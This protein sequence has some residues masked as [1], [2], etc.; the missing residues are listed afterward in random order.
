MRRLLILKL[1]AYG[2]LLV[3]LWA[4]GRGFGRA[5]SAMSG[6]SAAEGSHFVLWLL[7]YVALGVTLGLLAAWDFSTFLGSA[8]ERFVL[9]TGARGMR[10]DPRLKQ[11]EALVSKQEPLEAI[12]LLREYL[13]DKPRD[14]HAAIRIAEIYQGPLNN[15][16]AAVLEYEALLQHG[17]LPR[18]AR[19]W[20]LLRLGN[21]FLFLGR[22]DAATQWFEEIL[23]KYPR[24][25]AAEKAQRRLDAANPEA[26][27]TE[28]ADGDGATEPAGPEPASPPQVKLPPGFR[29][30]EE[31]APRR[32]FWQK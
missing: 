23:R 28:A 29:R 18:A 20:I 4:V 27:E 16:L 6:G 31:A 8:S 10:F 12:R 24:S 22:A 17:R 5:Y 11:A 14:W 30:R 15:P 1:A 19:P 7:A 9:G 2:A 25:A 3:G 32:W 13:A 21:G 26:P